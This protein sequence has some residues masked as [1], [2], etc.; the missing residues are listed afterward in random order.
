MS[1]YHTTERPGCSNR[2]CPFRTSG[3]QK[4]NGACHCLEEL[5]PGLRAWTRKQIR[6]AI[7]AAILDERE[8]AA[9]IA[10]E[11]A[12]KRGFTIE[13]VAD[14]IRARGDGK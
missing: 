3:G 14:R 8:A 1:D 4:T 2:G 9:R 6:D 11:L 7:Q 10:D 5:Q 13:D 12:D